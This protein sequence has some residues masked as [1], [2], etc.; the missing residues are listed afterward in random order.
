MFLFFE[1]KNF[2]FRGVMN[3]TQNMYLNTGLGIQEKLKNALRLCE[4]EN[5]ISINVESRNP[6]SIRNDSLGIG[7]L[8]T[9][10][11]PERSS[12]RRRSIVAANVTRSGVS[13]TARLRRSPSG[14]IFPRTSQAIIYR[15]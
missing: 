5:V 3:K 15:K 9:N 14:E 13:S 11:T 2:R 6:K 1:M 12:L 7:G 10:F 4:K 8:E